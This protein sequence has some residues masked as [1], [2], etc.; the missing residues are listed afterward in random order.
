MRW[1][2][3]S[4]RQSRIYQVGLDGVFEFLDLF[5][6]EEGEIGEHLFLIGFR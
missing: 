4:G 3:K 5:R 2:E 6:E 1:I